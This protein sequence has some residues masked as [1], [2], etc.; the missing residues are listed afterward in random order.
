MINHPVVLREYQASAVNRGLE[1]LRHKNNTLIIA[2]TGSGKTICLSALITEFVKSSSKIIK[3][4]VLQHRKEIMWQNMHK[5]NKVDPSISMSLISQESKDVTGTVVFAMVQTLYKNL[6]LME[7]YD[8]IVID[9]AHHVVAKSYLKIIEAART[10]NPSVKIYGV[11][12]TP[13]RG[14]GKRL[15]EIF[16]NISYA[17]DIEELIADGVLVKPKVYA[18]DIGLG[19]EIEKRMNGNYNLSNLELDILSS[20]IMQNFSVEL[21]K[22]FRYWQELAADRKTVVFT[23]TNKESLH[24]AN[25]F[26]QYGIKTAIITHDTPKKEREQIL[27]SFQFGDTQVLLNTSILTEGWDCPI[28]S[29][30]VLFKSSSH[31]TTYIQMVGRGLRSYPDKQD[32]IL[33][34]FGISTI[35]HGSLTQNIFKSVRNKE[36]IGLAE[37]DNSYYKACPN[38]KSEI[39]F[40]QKVCFICGFEFEGE[41]TKK[42]LIEEFKLKEIELIRT[43]EKKC[44]YLFVPVNDQDVVT[45]VGLK[46]W[47]GIFHN[48]KKWS[49]IGNILST[50][51]QTSLYY[52]SESK[53]DCFEQAYNFLNHSQNTAEYMKKNKDW[54]TSYPTEKQIEIIQNRTKGIIDCSALSRYEAT[55]L[56]SYFFNKK[57]ISQCLKYTQ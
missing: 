8:L 33:I 13:L 57:T 25:V 36:K 22:A 11:T 44:S 12:A 55:C 30:I 3:V 42:R 10:I 29:C 21:H 4:L 31:K 6:N 56:I 15:V 54:L 26:N 51:D 47:V 41:E 28:A 1:A 24:I 35:R 9:E 19:T 20:E 23:P 2:P 45:V 18:L 32:C 48:G 53:A 34:D 39:P 38:C 49:V 37:Q 17:I 5:F 50:D 52:S 16:N 43:I 7:H 40:A 14:D 27:N 46:S